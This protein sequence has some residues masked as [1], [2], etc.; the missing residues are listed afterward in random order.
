MKTFIKFTALALIAVF[1][2]VSCAPELELTNRDWKALTQDWDTSKLSI[3][4]GTLP[5]ITGGTTLTRNDE[6]TIFLQREADAARLPNAQIVAEMTKF[7]KFFNFTNNDTAPIIS[8]LGTEINYEFVRRESA[9]NGY[10]ITVRLLTAPT[11]RIVFRVIASEYTFANGNKLG[12]WDITS[13]GLNERDTFTQISPFELPPTPILWAGIANY[14][15]IALST[16]NFTGGAAIEVGSGTYDFTV[17]TILDSAIGSTFVVTDTN[18]ADVLNQLSSNIRLEKWNATTKRWESENATFEVRLPVGVVDP[19]SSNLVMRYTPGSAFASYRLIA[20]KLDN[21]SV[22]TGTT[23]R[24]VRVNGSFEPTQV[25]GTYHHIPVLTTAG[26]SH[27][28][29]DGSFVRPFPLTINH[30]EFGQDGRN[31]RLIIRAAPIAHETGTHYLG[32]MT[33]T[34]INNFVKIAYAPDGTTLSTFATIGGRN[35]I[36]FINIVSAEIRSSFYTAGSDRDEL[37]LTLD[38]TYKINNLPKTIMIGPGFAYGNDRI[39]FGDYSNIRYDFFRIYA[40]GLT[41]F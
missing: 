20:D 8:T 25:I 3:S 39:I 19:T 30:V 35:D 41:N 11:N 10:N 33:L 7:A 18:R 37:I 28:F 21:L 12:Q 4:R 32:N 23:S 38:P 22:T 27:Y 31:V 16:N 5:T 40:S 6:I 9:T 13:S 15:I 26:Q 34:N 36:S 24:K 14:G 17:A 29:V 2:V 1:A